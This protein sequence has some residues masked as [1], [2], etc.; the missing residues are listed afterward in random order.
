MKTMLRWSLAALT[1]AL[2]GAGL[3]RAADAGCGFALASYH[4]S[5]GSIVGMWQ[6]QFIA[7][8]NNGNPPDGT[9]IDNAFVQWHSDGTEIMNSSRDPATQSFCLGVW[10]QVGPRHYRL[11]HFA[12]SWDSIAGQPAGPA[13]VREDVVLSHNGRSFS[14]TFTID[15]YDESK[16]LLAHVVGRLEGRRITVS[17][18]IDSIS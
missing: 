4:D 15:Q 16:N 17:T 8:G 10:K 14:G 11:N 3:P 1:V 7:E 2:A 12:K 9:P 18:P 13:N 5:D 6:V